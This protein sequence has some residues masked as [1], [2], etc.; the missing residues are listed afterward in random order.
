MTISL[1]ILLTACVCYIG[2][3]GLTPPKKRRKA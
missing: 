2:K 3:D 1:M